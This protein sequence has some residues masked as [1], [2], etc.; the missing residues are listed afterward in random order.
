MERTFSLSPKESFLTDYRL[1]PLSFS[2]ER[3]LSTT[4]K[5]AWLTFQ[6]KP[7]DPRIRSLRMLLSEDPMLP[8]EE[9]AGL[10]MALAAATWQAGN[11]AKARRL[12]EKSLEQFPKRWASHRIL[13]DILMAQHFYEE[14]LNYLE[15]VKSPRRLPGWDS[16]FPKRERLTCAAACAWHLKQWDAV[17]SNLRRG[18]PKGPAQMPRP[19]QEDWFRLALYR[20]SPEDAAEAAHELVNV[21]ALEFTDAVLQ[22]LVQ[23]GWGEQALPLYRTMFS[24]DPR[25]QLLRRRLVA[26]CIKQG[27]ITEARAF[28]EPGAL[29]LSAGHYK[30][31]G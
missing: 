13:I 26:L 17:A 18:Y 1:P 7:I 31:S 15:A 22:T 24:E 30:L 25:N 9:Q 6:N 19:L 27:K 16:P 5:S 11:G 8:D 28:A 2:V 10:T 12:A 3:P 21:G 14:A 4:L 23:Q 20:Q 29:D